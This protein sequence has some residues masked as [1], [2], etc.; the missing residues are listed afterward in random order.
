MR[1]FHPNVLVFN[2]FLI[3]ETV[4][5]RNFWVVKHYFKVIV[6]LPVLKQSCLHGENAIFQLLKC[7]LAFCWAKILVALCIDYVGYN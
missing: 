2:T 6:K 1:L 3:A 5:L 7:F 4:A